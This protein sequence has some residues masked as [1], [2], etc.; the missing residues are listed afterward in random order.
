MER[1]L[2]AARLSEPGLLDRLA[3]REVLDRLLADVQSGQSGVLVIRGE[4]GIGKT[5]LIRYAERQATGLR[6]ARVG[7]VEAEMELPF[8]ALHQL[9]APM[10]ARLPALPKPQQDALTV[11]LG[12]TSGNP[13]DRFLVGLAVLSL[14]SAVAEE[15][16]L[17]CFVDDA[18]WLDAASSQALGFVARRLFAEAV[19]IVFALR[20]SADVRE[21]RSLPELLVGGLQVEDARALLAR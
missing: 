14:L 18:Q 12:L 8:A 19:G 21:F 1:D 9:C 11:A 10:L 13:P 17:L 3:E 20:E 15:Q 6:I 7:G 5:A 2:A 16:P 4:P